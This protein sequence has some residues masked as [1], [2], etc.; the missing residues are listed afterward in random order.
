[1][2]RIHKAFILLALTAIAPLIASP[3]SAQQSGAPAAATQKPDAQKEPDN[4][5]TWMREQLRAAASDAAGARAIPQNGNGV[6]NQKES[7]STDTSSTSLV[8]TS[9]ATDFASVAL[10]LIGVR[11][12]AA[13][14][15][16]PAS[17]SVTASLYSLMAAVNGVALT[18]PHY[19]KQGTAWRRISFTLGSEQ[20]TV[21]DHFTDKPSTNLGLKLLLLNRRDVYSTHAQTELRKMDDVVAAYV[22]LELAVTDDVQCVMFKF[23]SNPK[24]EVSA[25]PGI[26]ADCKRDEKGFGAFLLK[27]STGWAEVRDEITKNPEA[28]TQINALIV[29]LAA[30]RDV[31]DRGIATAVAQIQKAPQI[32]VAYFTRV[33]EDDGTDEHRLE[34]I[35][36]YGLS[37]RLNWTLNASFDYGDRKTQEDTKKGRVAT[38]FQAK[39]G[40]PT[41]ATG[42]KAATLAGSGEASKDP[43]TDWLLRAQIKLTVPIL[44]GI[45]IPIAY[46]YAN[47]DSEGITSGSQLKFS[48]AVD[49]VR[50]REYFR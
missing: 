19:Y 35:A 29:R 24:A 46:S 4:F 33:R 15:S 16:N 30:G 38:E 32:S 3:V 25:T 49:P 20:S 42:A 22:A 41:P 14:D 6:A 12:P 47:R 36:D 39:L 26:A 34:L 17:G 40:S 2:S 7:P 21:A 18:D 44:A 48:M 10:N 9:S 37:Q 11:P 27:L 28:M 45:D 31:A 23:L 5:S 13:G 50:L 1:M 8:D 43:G